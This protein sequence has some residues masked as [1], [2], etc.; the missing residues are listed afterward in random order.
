MRNLFRI[1]R[2]L[3]RY[4]WS[5]IFAHIALAFALLAQLSIPKIVQYVIDEGI[6]LDDRRVIL[7]GSL[8]IV[9]MAAIQGAFTYVRT[10]LFQSMAERVSTD[11]RAELYE[12]ML[13]LPFSYFD[14]S[15]SGQLMSR[16]TEDVNA[17][18]R[19]LMFSM[20]MAIFSFA[21]LVIVTV[22]LVREDALLAV[23]SL[24]VM[25]ALAWLAI[26]FG[27]NVRPM[28]SRVQQ[29]FGEM[30]SIMQENLAGTRVVRV[31]AQED[32]E[33]R[34]FDAS[35]RKL[36]SR[37]LEAIR[38]WSFYFPFMALVSSVSLVL[39]LWYGGRQVLAGSM[40]VGTLVAFNLYLALLSGPVRNLGW[41]V[42]SIARASASGERV[43]EVID[44][45]PAIR[46]A[47]SATAVEP[48][49]GE[50]RFE[51][52]SF[53]YPQAAE[54]A[55]SG[56][57]LE[58]GP[59]QII[60]LFGPTGAGKSTLVSLIPRFYDVTGGRV[61]VDGLDVRDWKLAALRRSIG[62]VMQESF[63][64]ST[65]IRENI[66]FGAPGATQEQVERAARIARAHDFIMEMPDGYDSVLGERGISLSGG[67]RQ[68]VA[69]ARA[70]CAD[71]R[72][73]I[74]DDA[75]SSVDMETEYEIQLALRAAMVGRTT[76][77]IA[78]RLATL[79]NAT[80]ILVLDRG[81]VVERGD[82]LSLL[83]RDGFYARIYDLQLRDQEQVVTAG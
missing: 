40:S 1:L 17:I 48:P 30:S 71:P 41:V 8:L 75:T 52:V 26:H 14:M 11:I 24:A 27:R 38:Y 18:R 47:A 82:H 65:T 64:F 13:T 55:L 5:L 81:V 62:I 29:Q 63:L 66:A 53:R 39:V 21:M 59:G 7:V 43:F 33:I 58:A 78:Q 23:L 22:L 50:V 3:R 32:A 15:Q 6:T 44:T 46:D 68:R 36:M 57:E 80:E 12:H 9:G 56:I 77:V 31:F 60:A 67:Q 61:M 73:L 19:F 74:L 25:P 76:F 28:F 35:I 2:Y 20:R 42:N 70:L 34:K 51:D 79:K 10:Y 83:A 54:L 45:R 37:Q 16:A 69:I 4:T 72:I 49:R